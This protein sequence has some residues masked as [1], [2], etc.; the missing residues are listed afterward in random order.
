MEQKIRD[1]RQKVE[2]A[3]TEKTLNAVIIWRL[4]CISHLYL[5]DIFSSKQLPVH[6]SYKIYIFISMCVPGKSNHNIMYHKLDLKTT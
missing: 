3:Y 6:L 4:K 2:K 5:A 1:L